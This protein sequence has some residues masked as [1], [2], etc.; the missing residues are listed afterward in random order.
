MAVLRRVDAVVFTAGIGENVPYVREKTLE[1]MENFGIIIDKNKNYETVSKEG[2]ISSSDSLVKVFVI[3][4]DEELRIAF[5][6][7]QLSK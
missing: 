1:N 4:T 7:Y 3:P 5:D 6:T 2:E